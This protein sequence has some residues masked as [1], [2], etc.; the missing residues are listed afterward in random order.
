MSKLRDIAPQGE[1]TAYD[2]HYLLT[3]AELLDADADGLDWATG[4]A[5]ILGFVA[6]FDPEAARRCW[7]SHLARAR[8]IIDEGLPGAIEKFGR[9]SRG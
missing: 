5:S 1:V 7:D 2:R 6:P 8:W 3:Y 4:A 9:K